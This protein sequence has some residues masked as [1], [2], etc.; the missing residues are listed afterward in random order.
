M[1]CLFWG[2]GDLKQNRALTGWPSA[3]TGWVER[4]RG[5]GRG[6]RETKR[7]IIP[8]LITIATIILID[9]SLVIIIAITVGEG[10][11][12]GED[13]HGTTPPSPQPST[14]GFPV[15]RESKDYEEEAKL[16]TRINGT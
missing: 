5:K 9:M 7:S 16:E 15:R 6:G 4:E 12:A 10:V 13:T 2:E 3:L 11:E 1:C 8:T 14:S